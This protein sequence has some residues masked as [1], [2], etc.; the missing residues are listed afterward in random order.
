MYGVNHR[1][2]KYRLIES[3]YINIVNESRNKYFDDK[4]NQKAEIVKLKGFFKRAL[5]KSC[6]RMMKL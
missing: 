4:T 5:F 1:I 6:I 2:I 3:E